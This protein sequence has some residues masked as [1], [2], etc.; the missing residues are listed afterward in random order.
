MN[1]HKKKWTVLKRY[2]NDHLTRIALPVGGIGTGTVSLG[3]RG[4]LRDWEIMNRPAKNFTPKATGRACY[5]SII[6]SVKPRNGNRVTR[7][8]EGPLNGWEYEGYAG[9][10]VPKR[11]KI[12]VSAVEGSTVI[13]SFRLVGYFAYIK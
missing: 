9:C 10:P 2:D 6:I 13:T 5:P 4:N 1:E 11:N 7:L 12:H 3:G 8:M